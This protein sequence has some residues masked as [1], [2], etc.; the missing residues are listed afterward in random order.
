MKYLLVLMLAGC[1]SFDDHDFCTL[2]VMQDGVKRCI[3]W[4][5]TPLPS[6]VRNFGK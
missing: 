3:A 6:Q 2:L 4:E 1:A 5:I